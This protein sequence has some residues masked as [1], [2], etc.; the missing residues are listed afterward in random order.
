MALGRKEGCN[1]LGWLVVLGLLGA[2]AS[3]R[4]CVFAQVALDVTLQLNS[5][6]RS[7]GNNF[8][9][10]GG[11][12]LGGNLFHSFRHFC[13]STNGEAFFN[14]VTVIGR[15][16]LPPSPYEAL[17]NDVIW[18]NTRLL[19]MGSRENP[20]GV[21]EHRLSKTSV[22]MHSQSKAWEILSE[23]GW[24]L[25]NKGEVISSTQS[26]HTVYPSSSRGSICYAQ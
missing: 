15:G 20:E 10:T 14:T 24:L 7:N 23:Q 25:N 13:V 26:A 19:S 8:T 5:V 1:Y 16:C 6:V 17:S 22:P 21:T 2:I 3:M 11:T 12:L 4:N 9:I 18:S